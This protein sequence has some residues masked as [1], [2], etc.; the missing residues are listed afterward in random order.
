M[1]L[2]F[3]DWKVPK[4]GHVIYW[5]PREAFVNTSG[6]YAVKPQSQQI[7][8]SGI[9][10]YTLYRDYFTSNLLDT[11][12]IRTW[13]RRWV[14][15]PAKPYTSRTRISKSPL[16]QRGGLLNV[17]QR[18]VLPNLMFSSIHIAWPSLKIRHKV[19]KYH[20]R[21]FIFC[22]H[23]YYI[24][25]PLMRLLLI[26]FQ[27]CNMLYMPQWE[28]YQKWT[29][30][31]AVMPRSSWNVQVWNMMEESKSC[32]PV[33]RNQTIPSAD[34]DHRTIGGH[35]QIFCMWS[36]LFYFLFLLI[37]KFFQLLYIFFLLLLLFLLLF[38]FDA[39]NPWVLSAVGMQARKVPC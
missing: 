11:R 6:R 23:A 17:E 30:E 38:L 12:R 5:W 14:Y 21:L 22:W 2:I 20:N 34:G 15:A 36:T 10:P 32:N 16:G 24:I 25:N 29:L 28:Q 8:H 35:E 31:E 33:N 39:A 27:I 19:H 13:W 26:Q 3:S 7:S 9:W 1:L 37:S 18:S 4:Y